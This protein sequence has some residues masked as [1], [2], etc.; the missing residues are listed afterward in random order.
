MKCSKIIV[1]CQPIY[2]QEGEINGTT[3]IDFIE[4][5]GNGSPEIPCSEQIKRKPES[6]SLSD[7][8]IWRPIIDVEYGQIINWDKQV[9]AYIHYR[10]YDNFKCI[11]KN[12]DGFVITMYNGFVPQFMCPKRDGYGNFIM[13]DIDE[14]GYIQH[15]D[16]EQVYSFLNELLK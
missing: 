7:H 1:V 6:E 4:S 16:K 2:W 10:V 3:D 14:C 5:K 8:Y 15:W 12:E 11:F 13:M 9:N